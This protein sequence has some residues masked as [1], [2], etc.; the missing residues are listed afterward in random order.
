[1]KFKNEHSMEQRKAES[2][3]IKTKYP[4]R[5]P[6]IVE[7]SEKSKVNDIDKKKY[8]VPADLTTGQFVYVI[9]KRLKLPAEQAIFLFIN[10]VI[11]PTAELLSNIFEQNKD[12]DGFLYITYSGENTF[13]F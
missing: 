3:R 2:D 9:R 13:G 1:M 6:V 12:E 5:L 10:G 7:K 8:L 11:P 4:D